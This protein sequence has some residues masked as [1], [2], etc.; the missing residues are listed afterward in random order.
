M[1]PANHCLAG[2]IY[3]STLESGSDGFELLDIAIHKFFMTF[4]EEKRPSTLWRLQYS[5]HQLHQENE[6]QTEVNINDGVVTFTDSSTDLAFDD[7]I[8]ATV[9]EAWT[10]ISGDT[11]GFMQF[12]DREIG[13]YDDEDA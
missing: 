10:E 13:A 3:A 11:E 5:Q 1:A 9:R 2:V 8:L 7:S 4:A 12:E 6:S